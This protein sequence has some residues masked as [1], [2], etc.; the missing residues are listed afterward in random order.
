MPLLSYRVESNNNIGCNK[1]IINS[2]NYIG[3]FD[4][5]KSA[6]TIMSLQT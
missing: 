4:E 1:E 3:E 5:G 6:T 2:I